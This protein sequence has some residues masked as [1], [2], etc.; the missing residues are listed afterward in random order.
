VPLLTDTR[1][2]GVLT[3][4]LVA[5]SGAAAAGLPRVR[6]EVGATVLNAVSVLVCVA[7]AVLSARRA[8]RQQDEAAGWWFIVAAACLQALYQAWPV[9]VVA[10]TGR[11]PAFPNASE[12]L[13]PA[14]LACIGASLLVWS[15]GRPRPVRLRTGVD[16]FLFGASILF[17]LWAAVL[18]SLVRHESLS[19]AEETL[20]ITDFALLAADLGLIVLLATG[21]GAR[22]GGT[23]TFIGAAL[24]AGTTNNLHVI[25]LGLNGR[26]YV[27]H[28]TDALVLLAEGLFALSALVPGPVLPASSDPRPRRPPAA[29]LV[30]YLPVVASLFTAA[31]LMS[32]PDAEGDRVLTTL[33]IAV[34]IA[35][36]L[37]QQLA[38]RDVEQ[39]SHHLTETVLE[40]TR[41]LGLAQVA[42]ARAQRLEAV[43]RMAGGVARDFDRLIHDLD[44]PVAVLAGAFPPSHPDREA[45]DEIAGARERAR[46]LTGQLLTFAQRQPV[47][48]RVVDVTALLA[49]FLPLLRRLAGRDVTIE[50]KT[51]PGSA[52]VFADPTQLEQLLSNL[53]VNARDAMPEGGTLAIAVAPVG[54]EAQPPEGG[55]SGRLVRIVVR[56]TGV[57][58]DEGTMAHIFEPFFTTKPA[59]KGTG[60][61]LPTC[62]GIVSRAGGH[63]QVESTPGAG[64]TVT[65][66][67]PRA[68]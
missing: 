53:T 52:P 36:V 24:L 35:L 63:I 23:L 49:D 68:T 11:L 21:I 64:T 59:G 18:H 45:V 29:S 34:G 9:S 8:R 27:G 62:Y 1:R 13:Q 48:P 47:E 38:L 3:V 15:H 56:D 2:T 46:R 14:M 7:A 32:E 6:P 20:L 65:V 58:M 5:V 30:P 31:L 57:G 33:G 37:R 41:E 28:P 40:R 44:E 25:F 54:A 39:L 51:A 60:L 17:V 10:A 12:L 67:L 55:P 4:L 61:G 66:D 42:L 22:L 43:G 50:L 26:Y 16:G 19:I